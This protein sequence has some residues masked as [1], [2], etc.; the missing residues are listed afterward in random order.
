MYYWRTNFQLSET[1]SQFLLTNNIKTLYIRFF[2][3]IAE[4][5]SVRPDATLLFSEPFPK[6]VEII[7]TVFIDTHVFSQAEI[8]D[9][10][11]EKIISR[12]DSMMVKNGYD[13]PKEIQ[14]DFDWTQSN[15][16]AYFKVL[17]EM[18]AKLHSANRHLSTTIRLHQLS[19][20]P[21]PADYGVLMVYNVGNFSSP[22][23]SNSILSIEAVKPYL[24]Y[25]ESYS[26]PLA[27]ALPIFS[28]NL[29]FRKDKFLLIARGLN[30]NDTTLFEPLGNNQ[31]RAFKY[32][33]IPGSTGGGRLGERLYPNDIIR[34]EKA[35]YETLN[36]VES[37]IAGVRPSA[38]KR[39]ILYHLDENAIKNYKSD[40]LENLFSIR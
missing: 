30:P 25:L 33:A 15:R 39:I 22:D 7:P 40:E 29:L 36:S 14:I 18:A 8:P 4:N 17:E 5:G 13:T 3:V 1:E 32:A 38:V 23:E 26:L 16:E 20:S 19:Q 10:F 11:A 35:E 24:G 37:L 9:D 28:W 27:T 2:D 12:I 6:G 31:Y 21:P 34:F